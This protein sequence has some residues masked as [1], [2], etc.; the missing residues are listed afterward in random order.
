MLAIMDD[1]FE[2]KP[3]TYLFQVSPS[4][5]TFGESKKVWI[6]NYVYSI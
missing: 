5:C 4:M 3:S 6:I 2:K 1:V